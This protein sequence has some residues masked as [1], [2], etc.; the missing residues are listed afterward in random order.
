MTPRDL[1]QPGDVMGGARCSA[2]SRT[3]LPYTT[4]DSFNKPT[5]LRQ[6]KNTALLQLGITKMQD[7]HALTTT[8]QTVHLIFS[9]T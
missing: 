2:R 3:P 1:K 4:Q 8:R 7:G 9:K 6:Y 5:L